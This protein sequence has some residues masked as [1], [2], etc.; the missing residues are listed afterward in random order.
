M[1]KNSYIWNN[2]VYH[3]W[4]ESDLG[5]INQDLIGVCSYF[6]LNKYGVEDTDI[7]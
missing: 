4:K 5:R 3:I 1:S 7:Y 6:I 2:S